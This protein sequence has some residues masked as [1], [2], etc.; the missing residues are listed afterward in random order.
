MLP[1]LM[2]MKKGFH[3]AAA[4]VEAFGLGMTP[5]QAKDAEEFMDM[6]TRIKALGKGLVITFAKGMIPGF[7]KDMKGWVNWGK[8][9]RPIF[10]RWGEALRDAFDRMRGWWKANFPAWRKMAERWWAAFQDG[11]DVAREWL[12]AS[13]R[14]LAE[15]WESDATL[16]EWRRVGA[17]WAQSVGDSFAETWVGYKPAIALTPKWLEDMF[18][19]PLETWRETWKGLKLEYPWLVELEKRLQHVLDMLDRLGK[20]YRETLRGLTM[21][22]EEKTGAK[23]RADVKIEEA[24]K[25]FWRKLGVVS[26]EEYQQR[27]AERRSPGQAMRE[28]FGQEFRG[29]A[30]PTIPGGYHGGWSGGGQISYTPGM[31]GVTVNAPVTLQITGNVDQRAIDQITKV[32]GDALRKGLLDAGLGM[33]GPIKALQ[34]RVEGMELQT[35]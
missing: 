15:W 21:P 22:A 33:S 14:G 16:Q 10:L 4:E 26:P 30:P 5:K 27:K 29:E 18:E 31:G 17:K 3:D 2:A 11:W 12:Q 35:A 24:M 6:L 8:K 20:S 13:W 19:K 25:G 23:T 28:E 9:L 32:T 34:G 7:I 1:A